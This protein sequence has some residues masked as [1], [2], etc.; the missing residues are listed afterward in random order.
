M[1]VVECDFQQTISGS[2][3]TRV[4][5]RQQG[6]TMV[7]KEGSKYRKWTR[8][9]QQEWVSVDSS[10]YGTR[11]ELLQSLLVLKSKKPFP[12]VIDTIP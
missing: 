1:H 6:T 3:A 9:D 7:L 5:V 10:L 12:E 8:L 4:R 2:R 11:V